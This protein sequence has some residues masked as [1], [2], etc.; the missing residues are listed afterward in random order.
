MDD[1]RA[2]DFLVR[3]QNPD[4]G[5]GYRL[6]SRSLVEPTA[7]CALALATSGKTQE[8]Q[9]AMAFLKRCQGV[10]GS[11][12]LDAEEPE[13][14][15]M[16]YAALLAF[17][18]LGAI[19]EARRLK[20]WGLAFVDASSRLPP[21]S[22]AAIKADFRFD[23]SIPGWPWTAGTS[24]WVEPTAMF[25]IALLRAG[26]PTSHPRIQQG[27]A[28]I[29]DRRIPSGGWNFGNPFSGS[30]PLEPNLLSTA[31]A[32]TALA[33][34]GIGETHPAV[35]GGIQFVRGRFRGPVSVVS[36]C[37]NC[38]ALRTFPSAN[39]MVQEMRSRL[40][41]LQGGDGGFRGNPFETALAVLVLK[42]PGVLTGAEG[43]L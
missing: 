23:A 6:A 32:L 4:G 7:F 1:K 43:G 3:G 22:I 26:V 42:H 30:Y 34:A 15:W 19:E 39:A 33:V 11:V 41:G 2:A 20:E 37:W 10:D 17:Q 27:T 21:A 16:A 12:G 35:Q 9:R 8:S 24:G 29:L 18:G 5:F 13:G 38:L 25:V 14:N 28:L 31:L 40:S 36:L